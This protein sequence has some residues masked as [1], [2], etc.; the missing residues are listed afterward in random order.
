MMRSGGVLRVGKMIGSD[1]SAGRSGVSTPTTKTP[2]VYER[3]PE[4]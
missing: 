2:E 1:A 3:S 4:P